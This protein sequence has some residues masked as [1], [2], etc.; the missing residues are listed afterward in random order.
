MGQCP[1]PLASFSGTVFWLDF[2]GHHTFQVRVGSGQGMMVSSNALIIASS[3]HLPWSLE[4][5]SLWGLGGQQ[6]ECQPGA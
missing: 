4:V 6:N 5:P 3:P 1:I 2:V